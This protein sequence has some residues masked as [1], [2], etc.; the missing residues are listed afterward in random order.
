MLA[1]RKWHCYEESV[2]TLEIHCIAN[3][4]G[5]FENTEKLGK[6]RLWLK[7]K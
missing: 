5:V 3:N 1:Q 6:I 7:D 2:K 4:V